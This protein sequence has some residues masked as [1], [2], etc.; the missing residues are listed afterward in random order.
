MP[1]SRLVPHPASRGAP[2]LDLVALAA[3]LP[4]GA[5]TF[6]YRVTGEIARVRVPAAAPSARTD[7]LWRH[8]CF[9]AFLSCGESRYVELNFA[10][11]SAW[12]AYRF[13]GYRSGMRPWLE[14]DAPQI[15]FSVQDDA[16]VLEAMLPAV[17]LPADEAVGLSAVV[18]DVD[19]DVSYWALAHSD[20]ARPDFHMA[21]SWTSR[22]RNH[23]FEDRR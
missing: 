12:A 9:E 18:E 4:D 15:R 2:R 7:E 20:P 3:R 21:A 5:V 16:L 10:P 23:R 14:I 1:F 22:L 19:G 13:D 8:T 17:S 6:R 11:S